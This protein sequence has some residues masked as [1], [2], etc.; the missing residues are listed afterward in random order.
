[1]L[2]FLRN[3]FLQRFISY[4]TIRQI[5]EDNKESSKIFQNIT[6][7]HQMPQGLLLLFFFFFN[8]CQPRP[9]L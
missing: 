3:N 4:P 5:V 7:T 6:S 8:L 2:I 9:V 1:M